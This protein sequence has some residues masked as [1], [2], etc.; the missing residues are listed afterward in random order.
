M[1]TNPKSDGVVAEPPHDQAGVV[2]APAPAAPAPAPAPIPEVKAQVI[3]AAVPVAEPDV[4][5]V[6][7]AA[8]A[9][10]ATDSKTVQSGDV[11]KKPILPIVVSVVFFALLCILAVMAYAQSK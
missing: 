10:D 5:T 4:K 11:T 1:D 8:T 2:A 6:S 7:M 3:Q 9:P